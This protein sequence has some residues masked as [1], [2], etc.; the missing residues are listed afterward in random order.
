M[1]C[2]SVYHLSHTVTDF[3]LNSGLGWLK[4]NPSQNRLNYQNQYKYWIM[5]TP[6]SPHKTPQWLCVNLCLHTGTEIAELVF[7]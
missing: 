4:P 7:F 2:F 1:L 3:S 5:E 6:F